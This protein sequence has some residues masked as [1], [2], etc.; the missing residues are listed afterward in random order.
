MGWVPM[1]HKDVLI[2]ART[3]MHKRTF[4]N[5]AAPFIITNENEQRA[6]PPSLTAFRTRE[7]GVA[8]L[9][10]VE[11]AKGTILFLSYIEWESGKCEVRTEEVESDAA[12]VQ[13]LT[14][15]LRLGV[16]RALYDG[17]SFDCAALRSARLKDDDTWSNLFDLSLREIDLAADYPAVQSLREMGVAHI[18]KG[19]EMPGRT[20]RRTSRE[21]ALYPKGDQLIPLNIFLITRLMPLLN[22]IRRTE[23][24]RLF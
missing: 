3:S 14:H 2:V 4:R 19:H 23:Q 13:R 12:S 10:S 7:P 1:Q 20:K 17:T 11:A 8:H 21:F 15:G 16:E 24:L 22:K 18:L 6:I 9:Y 5:L